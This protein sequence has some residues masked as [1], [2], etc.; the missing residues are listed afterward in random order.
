[1]AQ[2]TRSE[3]G[4]P[5]AVPFFDGANGPSPQS[6]QAETFY[7][8]ALQHLTAAGLSFL[9][10]GTYAVWAY[11]GISRPTKDLDIFC[12]PGQV[13]RILNLFRTLGYSIRIEDERW[14]AKV[15]R[16]E[17]YFDII[18]AAASGTMPVGDEWFA[19]SR[20]IELF[21]MKARIVGPTELVWS[22]AFIQVRHRYDGADIAHV[23]LK[24]HDD[25]DWQRLLSH[26]EQYWEVL[27][28]HLLNFRFV[29]PSERDCVPRWL[30]D[31]L[32]ERLKQQL[33]LPPPERKLCRGRMF[34]RPDYEIDVTRWDF[35]DAGG[36]G[37]WRDE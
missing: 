25:I 32:I 4:S 6:P 35:A 3:Q 28:M 30:M 29:Y 10:A 11:T 33:E 37:E 2:M 21:G 27:L 26:M 14:L 22:K 5:L 23:I 31:E 36:E 15:G 1:M 19:Y 13:P 8:E 18:F 20:E 7:A 12:K 9:L 16:G 17:L 24:Q 34:S